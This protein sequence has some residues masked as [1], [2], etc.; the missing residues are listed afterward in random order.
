[1]EDT[2]WS[3]LTDS[4]IQTPMALTAESLAGKYDISREE[5]DKQALRSQQ[6]WA[7]GKLLSCV[8]LVLAYPGGFMPGCRGCIVGN[9]YVNDTIFSAFHCLY[10]HEGYGEIA[11][12]DPP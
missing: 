12:C 8:V 9:L 1:M 3:S 11:E 2:L 5:C 4:Y 10:W 6:R 7:A